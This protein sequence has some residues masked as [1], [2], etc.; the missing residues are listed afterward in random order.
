MSSI[1]YSVVIESD[2]IVHVSQNCIFNEDNFAKKNWTNTKM[3]DK[4][5]IDDSTGR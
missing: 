1:N 2:K 5:V 3:V 4:T